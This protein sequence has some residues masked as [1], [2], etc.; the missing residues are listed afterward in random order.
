MLC[1]KWLFFIPLNDANTMGEINTFGPSINSMWYLGPTKALYTT[2][3][4]FWK[5]KQIFWV[6]THI[7]Q[8][9]CSK[10]GWIVHGMVS[11]SLADNM[12]KNVS[13]FSI[14][15]FVVVRD[16]SPCPVGSSTNMKNGC[17]TTSRGKGSSHRHISFFHLIRMSY[18]LYFL[19]TFSN[20]IFIIFVLEGRSRR[21]VSPS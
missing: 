14:A 1:V 20:E 12:G 2:T 9:S 7:T 3:S 6:N 17:K 21:S 13:Y 16:F 5:S 10:N 18:R 4:L 8:R 19:V 11:L 15:A